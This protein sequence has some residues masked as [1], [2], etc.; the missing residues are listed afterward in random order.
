M[1]KNA[2]I[3]AGLCALGLFSWQTQAMSIERA[4]II[5]I[6]DNVPT[7]NAK[8]PFVVKVAI[9]EMDCFR[10]YGG[11]HILQ[12]LSEVS[13]IELVFKDMGEKEIKRFLDVNGL[14]E[15]NNDLKFD[16]ISNSS[17]YDSLNN[18][19]ITE[20]H[21]YSDEGIELYDLPLASKKIE[22]KIAE[23]KAI[24]FDLMQE[25]HPKLELKYDSD[26][27]DLS[28]SN[29]YYLI[30]NSTMNCCEVFDKKGNSLYT[31]DA[32][33]ID[34]M[35]IF[36]EMKKNEK[37]AN[38]LKRTGAFSCRIESAQMM[39][40]EVW[41]NVMVPYI[42]VRNDSIIHIYKY[43][44]ISYSANGGG[45]MSHQVLCDSQ[46]IPIYSI[47]A[48]RN[49]E[50]YFGISMSADEEK[51]FEYKCHVMQRTIGKMKIVNTKEIWLPDF[52]RIP[53]F[54][55]LPKVKDGLLALNYTDFLLDLEHDTIY[56]LPIHSNPKITGSISSGFDVSTDG[57]VKDWTCDG[58]TLAI[59]YHDAKL[60]QY[61]Y[62]FKDDQSNKINVKSLSFGSEV[63]SPSFCLVS[64]HVL[65]YL[66]S[67]NRVQLMLID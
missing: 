21:V 36:Q 66:N 1:K 33:Q 28:V 55:Y 29:A 2:L 43:C 40:E 15:K 37:Y 39:G 18:F 45:A 51:R 34:P 47:G 64:P 31:I 8:K 58:E 61:R 9:N 56:S 22:R 16:I 24:G 35:E 44:Q 12:Q 50:N 67:E 19:G 42:E 26:F 41:L 32:L 23:I 3:L 17:L 62:L 13:R 27:Y 63:K 30:T 14:K 46:D 49:G 7:G 53:N 5:T 54:A 48:A 65:Y 57:Q 10:C 4:S 38:Y 11:T 6:E 59:V 25:N 20:A 60:M 52:N